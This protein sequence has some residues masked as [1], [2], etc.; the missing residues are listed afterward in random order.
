MIDILNNI[1]KELNEYSNYSKEELFTKCI[2]ERLDKSV[3][4]YY[5][6]LSKTFN[7][8]D[9]INELKVIRRLNN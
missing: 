4:M 8:L 2:S 1:L 3:E 7:K 5:M 6:E 9:S